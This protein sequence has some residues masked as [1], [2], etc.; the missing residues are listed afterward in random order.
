[1][2]DW[3]ADRGLVLTNRPFIGVE[4][5]ARARAEWKN[6]RADRADRWADRKNPR[7]DRADRWPLGPRSFPS[8]PELPELP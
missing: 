3:W 5:R 2:A 1:M 4:D 7:A 6:P 8:L